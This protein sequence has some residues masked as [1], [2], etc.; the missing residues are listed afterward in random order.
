ME[1][2]DVTIY[3]G[4]A[5]WIDF[6]WLFSRIHAK[7]PL[8]TK[9]GRMLIE[10]TVENHRAFREKQTFSMVASSATQR[11]DP[12]HVVQSGFKTVPFVLLESCLFGAN[13]SGKSSLIDAMSF[14]S[15]FVRTSFR[16]EPGKSI[17]VE[18]FLFH[19]DWRR[20]PSEF[21]VIF[22]HDETLYQYGFA[23][24]KAR[25]VEEWL[26][27]RP[28][29]TGRQRQLFTRSYDEEKGS[30]DW[31]ISSVHVKGERDSWKAQTR[32]EALF[33]STAV[34]LNAE[35]L[36]G[37]YE[38]LAFRFRSLRGPEARQLDYTETRFGE[39]GWKERVISFLRSND[40]AL[41][42]IRVEE[43]KLLD[44]DDIPDH[45]RGLIEEDD[46]DAKTYSIE[47]ARPDESEKLI[48]LPFSEES[49]GTQNLFDLA[50]P[51]LDVIDNGY[52]I[53]IDELNSGLHP[54][55]FQHLIALFCDPDVNKHNAQLIF[56]T[57]DSSL[58]DSSCIGRDQVWM[59]EK[60]QD[61]AARLTPLSD[62]KPRHDAVGYQKRYLQGRFGGVPRLSE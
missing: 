7:N 45:I 24:T 49:T 40:I 33:L 32:P 58:L 61:L 17:G 12:E 43:G 13:G 1:T 31:D 25:V 52:T 55:A 62:F 20:K 30:Y 42:D 35:G 18:P 23:L 29:S 36:R 9:A 8:Q 37:A 11:A 27:A 21:E 41:S 26:F 22:I 34:Q 14:M 4:N 5:T 44:N 19:S 47:F 28:K 60:G 54:L 16:N 38:W 39:K 59:V 50:G 51:I 3:D 48:P 15:R 6:G 56:T 57:H 2:L 53:I 46:P 10:F